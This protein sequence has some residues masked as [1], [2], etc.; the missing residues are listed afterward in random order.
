[1]GYT[2]EDREEVNVVYNNDH[3][4]GSGSFLLR[5]KPYGLTEDAVGIRPN[6]P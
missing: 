1:M 3:K 5:N 6:L 2:D 4:Q